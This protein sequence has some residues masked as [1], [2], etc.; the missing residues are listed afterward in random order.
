ML[1]IC[2]RQFPA[3]HEEQYI[4]RKEVLYIYKWHWVGT[5]GGSLDRH[6]K[7]GYR[8]I[9]QYILQPTNVSTK[10]RQNQ[11]LTFNILKHNYLLN[12]SWH[13]HVTIYGQVGYPQNIIWT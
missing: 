9:V 1:P 3:A 2:T 13:C 8:G 5:M 12:N 4:V 6:R 11:Q 10:H 7:R